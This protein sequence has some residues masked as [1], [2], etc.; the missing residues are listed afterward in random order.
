MSSDICMMNLKIFINFR[1]I[2][3]MYLLGQIYT[4]SY[5]LQYILNQENNPSIGME[6]W[7]IFLYICAAFRLQLS[8]LLIKVKLYVAILL[9]RLTRYL[10]MWTRCCIII[11]I[12]YALVTGL[13]TVCSIALGF[14]IAHLTAKQTIIMTL[15]CA[16]AQG[17]PG[18][19]Q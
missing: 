10:W 12:V 2:S 1:A 4:Y 9:P 18:G 6:W 13:E 15:S 7:E 14:G 8:L 11:I 5:L 17:R 19:R 3:L 16:A